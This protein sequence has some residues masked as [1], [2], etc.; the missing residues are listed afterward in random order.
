MGGR[1]RIES[2][3]RYAE[4]E[5]RLS[6]DD[7]GSTLAE[8]FFSSSFLLR[9]LPSKLPWMRVNKNTPMDGSNCGLRCGSY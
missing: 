2:K 7:R 4:A 3:N 5:P 1:R 6:M 9:V 8:G